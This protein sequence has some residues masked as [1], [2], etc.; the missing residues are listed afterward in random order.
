MLNKDQ[1]KK[2]LD[3]DPETGIF[4]W[5]I[6]RGG[7]RKG[8]VSGSLNNRGYLSIMVNGKNY[9]A[10]RLA[11]LYVHGEFPKQNTDHINRKKI[12]NR[13]I[14]LRMCS[15]SQNQANCLKRS[16]NTSGY[17]GVSWCKY[18]NKW[19]AYIRFNSKRSNL[20]Y[21]SDKLKAAIAYNEKAVELFGEFAYLN[22]VNQLKE[23]QC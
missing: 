23:K 6:S 19:N 18:N 15:N 1:M 14:N 11:W 16:D 13:I 9:Q 21:F 22:K 12:D 7:M 20:G 17:K 10:H 4:R 8:A 2:V 3:Y 5:K